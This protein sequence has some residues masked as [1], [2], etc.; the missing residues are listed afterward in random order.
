MFIPGRKRRSDSIQ[1]MCRKTLGG[2][3]KFD[4]HC[5]LSLILFYGAHCA[6]SSKQVEQ[7]T[8]P[9]HTTEKH[10]FRNFFKLMRIRPDTN[11]EET[12]RMLSVQNISHVA[13]TIK[14]DQGHQNWQENSTFTGDY[15]TAQFERSRIKSVQGPKIKVFVEFVKAKIIT[16]LR[17]M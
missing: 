1:W 5:N 9:T 10:N 15:P 13:V 7:D 8:R 11:M 16:F 6:F 3:L 17:C 12:K 14:F 4:R 2:I